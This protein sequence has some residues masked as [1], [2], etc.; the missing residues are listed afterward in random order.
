MST[1]LTRCFELPADVE[2]VFAALSSEGWAH[3]K[4]EVLKDG[5]QVVR[6]EEKPDGGV[7]LVVSR[8][9]PE[10]VPSFLEKFL[11]RDGRADQTDDWGPAAADGARSGRWSAEIPGAPAQVGGTMRLEPSGAGCTYTIN[12]EVKVRV[13][14]VGGK[15][16]KFLAGMV[17]RLTE[18]EAD[19]LVEIVS[20]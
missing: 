20:C 13:P 9:L 17:G 18:K 12:G 14:L 6:R 5:S 10:G 19:V 15:A 11:P 3:R 7:L 16:E 4:A 1:S 2:T 8:E